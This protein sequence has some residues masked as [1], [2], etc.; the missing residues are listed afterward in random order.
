MIMFVDP[1]KMVH[2]LN[3]IFFIEFASIKLYSFSSSS[4]FLFF[5]FFSFS[6]VIN[7][8]LALKIKL[9]NNLEVISWKYKVSYQNV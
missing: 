3:L 8:V 2:V 9:N 7:F 1:K 6:S 5:I 4:Y